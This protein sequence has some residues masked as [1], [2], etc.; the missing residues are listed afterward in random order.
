MKRRQRQRV[1]IPAPERIEAWYRLRYRAVV[2]KE[3]ETVPASRLWELVKYFADN[4]A[5]DV[6]DVELHVTG[7]P[8]W[9]E[10]A[11]RSRR[12]RRAHRLGQTYWPELYGGRRQVAF[13]VRRH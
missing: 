1:R 9:D 10:R 12:E 6:T 7:D 11:T 2:G 4:P 8:R 13:V 3:P 5:L